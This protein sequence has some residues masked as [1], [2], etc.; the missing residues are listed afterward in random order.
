M[1]AICSASVQAF[2]LTARKWEILAVDQLEEYPENKEL[3]NQLVIDAED[4]QMI[5]AICQTYAT[6]SHHNRRTA[7]SADIIQGKGEG[8]IF[9]LHGKPGVGKFTFD[10][11][12]NYRS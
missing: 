5:K 12:T 2:V 7:W 9:L 10:K 3:I 6:D 11:C 4:K 8:Q 1:Y